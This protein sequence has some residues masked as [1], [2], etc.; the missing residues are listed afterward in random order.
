VPLFSN[1]SAPSP[2]HTFSAPQA[3]VVELLASPLPITEK[4]GAL[5]KEI[6]DKVRLFCSRTCIAESP[7]THPRA[8]PALLPSPLARLYISSIPSVNP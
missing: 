4:P 2:R 1:F 7:H 3:A 8:A 6:E 5:V